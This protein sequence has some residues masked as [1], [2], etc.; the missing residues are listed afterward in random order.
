MA[1]E[2][3]AISIVM[4]LYNKAEQVLTTIASVQAQIWRDWELIVVDDG[5]T[6]DGLACV[7]ALQ[8]AR[9]R[10][11]SQTNQGVSAARNHGIALAR[12][13]LVALL[14][15]DDSWQP[16]FLATVASLARDFP[17]AGWFATGYRIQHPEGSPRDNRLL[18]IPAGFQRGILQDYFQVAMQSDPPAWTSAVMTRKDALNVIGGFPVGVTS[19]EDLLTWARLAVRFPLA[20]DCRALATF[21][22]SGIS[23]APDRGDHVGLALLSLARDYPDQMGLLDYL[24]LWFRMQAV[25]ALRLGDRPTARRF[26]WKATRTA[27]NQWRNPYTLLLA[28]LPACLSA[29]LDAWLRRLMN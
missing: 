26:A 15:A 3:P 23:R 14:D 13:E 25:K 1:A 10:C 8:D 28:W 16:D 21:Y 6:D 12:A 20:Y 22:A 29:R 2:V 19:G 27:P 17:E 24:G 18:G 4:P 5:S 7:R 11:V 9:I